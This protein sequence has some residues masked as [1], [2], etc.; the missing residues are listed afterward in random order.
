MINQHL[1]DYLTTYFLNKGEQF[2]LNHIISNHFMEI[3]IVKS[4]K[5]TYRKVGILIIGH[6]DADINGQ[7]P[8]ISLIELKMT[9]NKKLN[10]NDNPQLLKWIEEGWLIKEIRLKQD[11]KSVERQ[12]YRMG[13]RLFLYEQNQ[14]QQ[15]MEQLAKELLELKT[16]YNNISFSQDS[17]Y[18]Q[19][20]I[21]IVIKDTFMEICDI[22]NLKNTNCFPKTW[23]L[24]KRIKFLHFI[25][26]IAKLA[27]TKQ[28]FD[29]KEIGSAYYQK[30]GGS[31]VFDRNQDEFL[32][33]FEEWTSYPAV[34]FGLTSLGYITPVFFAG[35]VNGQY[36]SY[37]YGPVHALTNL[38]IAMDKYETTSETLWIVENRGILTRLAAEFTFLQEQSILILCCDGHIRS[39]HRQ[40]IQQ[41][42]HNSQLK[43]VLIWTDYD[44]DGVI[45]AKELYKIIAGKLATIK[46]IGPT[47]EIYKTWSDYEQA[48]EQFLKQK[49]MEQEEMTGDVTLWKKWI[50]S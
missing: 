5:R 44:D 47:G 1:F 50:K 48:M 42:I 4:T 16:N 27:S 8:D 22:D 3:P 26:A 13:Y 14:K 30:I 19:Q 41:L 23:L 6:A 45:I 17:P 25:L 34:D 24:K 29:W 38:S 11:G 15:Q 43:Q 49:K 31:K 46:W 36:S 9:P 40:F 35:Q 2:D 32:Q 39:A 37:E 18:I 7:I 33:L 28:Q 10:I 21:F 20:K 12:H